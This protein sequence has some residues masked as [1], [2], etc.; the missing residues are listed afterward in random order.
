MGKWIEEGGYI[1]ALTAKFEN[2]I[3]LARIS[4][5]RTSTGYNACKGV[6]PILKTASNKKTI[7]KNADPDALEFVLSLTDAATQAPIQIIEHPILAK[8][9]RGRRPT[10]S[11]SDAPNKAS[12]NC[13]Q[14]KPTL[15]FSWV[16]E[17][18]IPAVSRTAEMK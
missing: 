5:L 11:T 7:A 18:L 12:A 14:F 8:R 9:R 4:K 15:T 6:N 10:R 3:P 1:P 17:F 2:A 13:M 16:M